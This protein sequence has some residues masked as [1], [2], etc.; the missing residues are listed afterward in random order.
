[1]KANGNSKI[2]DVS[3]YGAKG[4]GKND[5]T[6]S[7][8]K[9]VFALHKS[10]EGS[11]L[12]FPKGR[13]I[14][15]NDDSE[16]IV[17]I[18]DIDKVTID[19]QGSEII[20]TSRKVIPISVK[21]S[22]GVTLKNM[23]IYWEKP[24]FSQGKV[25]SSTESTIDV[26]F[27]DEYPVNGTEEIEALMDY[28]PVSKIPI[29]NLDVFGSAIRKKELTA[30]QM[31]KLT[32]KTEW[33]DPEKRK[34]VS[35]TLSTIPAGTII[36]LR[37]AIYG[38][39]G[40]DINICENVNI[41]NVRIWGV[42]GMAV[43]MSQCKDV[44]VKKLIIEPKPGTGR[45]MSCT[46]DAFFF[47]YPMGELAI[48]DSRIEAAGDDCLPLYGKF[49]KL[50]EI[51][52]RK[53]MKLKVEIGWQGPTA[54]PGDRIDIYGG[55]D[56]ALKATLSVESSKFDQNEKLH[57]IKFNEEI[58][59]GVKTGDV[60]YNTAFMCSKVS[61]KNT[62]L[63]SNRGRAVF[64]SAR[65]VEFENVKIYGTS[66][67]G[68]IIFADKDRSSRPGPSVENFTFKNCT[69]DSCALAPLVVYTGAPKPAALQKNINVIDCKFTDRSEIR[70]LRAK[71]SNYKNIMFYQAG[72]YFKD[73]SRGLISGNT[74]E[75]FE[76]AIA[77]SNTQDVTV[78]NNRCLDSSP[79]RIVNDKAT[80][81]NLLLDKNINF[82]EDAEASKYNFSYL[83]YCDMR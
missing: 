59:S 41:E 60:G 29:G 23:I 81:T 16:I 40:I 39:Y 45:I 61:V 63:G 25:I 27:D 83:Y 7:I 21:N 13:Y 75:G 38:Q 34:Y 62:I 47:I 12:L 71:G 52:D 17:K 35:R 73:V 2:I 56:L 78:T 69:F 22:K 28:D 1:M 8:Q 44:H 20:S 65:N 4:D 57:V 55:N 9:A 46:A 49:L 79:S 37:H 6:A 43:H 70:R 26:K 5:D 48:E 18:D 24:Y 42:P 30:P 19:G 68:A 31:L 3:I 66:L 54:R 82:N 10:G 14:V 72:I 67:A 51:V 36:L 76:D 11:T 80:N 15:R 32:F 77:I 58:P 53:T 74:F 33:G 50:T 64:L